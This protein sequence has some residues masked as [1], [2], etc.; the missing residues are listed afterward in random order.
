MIHEKN[1]AAAALAHKN[2]Q[3]RNVKEPVFE[4][5]ARYWAYRV[6]KVKDI[7]FEELEH[8]SHTWV[9]ERSYNQK[10]MN[11]VAENLRTGNTKN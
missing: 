7:T 4:L 8:N 10:L 1:P 11:K 3:I 5:E 2:R 9:G 6:A